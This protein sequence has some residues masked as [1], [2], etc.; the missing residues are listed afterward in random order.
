M[1]C[2]RDHGSRSDNSSELS[3]KHNQILANKERWN[4]NGKAIK[5]IRRTI[6][7]RL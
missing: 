3:G 1:W 4:Y 7:R 5:G 2:I 6:I